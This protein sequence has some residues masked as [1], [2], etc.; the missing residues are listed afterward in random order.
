MVMNQK[1]F[2]S[3]GRQVNVMYLPVMA[4][5]PIKCLQAEVPAPALFFQPVKKLNRLHVMAKSIQSIL[6]A[7]PVK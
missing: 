6:T 4:E 5:D 2:I 1:I 7:D 3:L